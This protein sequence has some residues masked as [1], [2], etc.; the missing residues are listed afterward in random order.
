MIK[1]QKDYVTPSQGLILKYRG[2]FDLKKLYSSVKEW[3]SK[4]NYDLSEKEYKEKPGD[5]G[6][7]FNII[8]NCER[9][10]DEYS[11]FNIDLHFFILN[12]KKTNGKYS[13]KINIY[14]SAYVLLDR[15]DKWQ[16]NS[17]KTFLFFVYN[18]FFIKDKIQ[19]VY[20]DKLYS[21][22][23]DLI[24]IIKKHVNVK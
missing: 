15:K 1:G 11:S 7:E 12:A 24:S 23:L 18:N 8:F 5:L 3:F 19:N 21:E 17:I 16:S 2:E 9:K 6:K 4:K 14:V 13:G 10:I 20:E 22:I